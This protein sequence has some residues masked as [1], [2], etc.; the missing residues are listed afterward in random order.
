MGIRS[1]EQFVLKYLRFPCFICRNKT[2]ATIVI[3]RLIPEK[4]VNTTTLYIY[5]DLIAKLWSQ[6]HLHAWL[7]IKI[8]DFASLWL[9][10]LPLRGCLTTV[11]SLTCDMWFLFRIALRLTF[12]QLYLCFDVSNKNMNKDKDRSWL[13]DLWS[14]YWNDIRLNAWLPVLKKKQKKK[15]FIYFVVIIIIIGMF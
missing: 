3:W 15:H 4:Y 9:I 7:W 2:K 1:C 14:C 5:L 10:G 8:F 12:W 11:C 6:M 13:V